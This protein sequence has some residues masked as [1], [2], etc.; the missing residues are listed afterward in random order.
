MGYESWR[1]VI[2]VLHFSLERSECEYMDGNSIQLI[3][4]YNAILKERVVIDRTADDTV[5]EEYDTGYNEQALLIK[6]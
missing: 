3:N 4:F 2:Y 5:N 1:Y 6:S